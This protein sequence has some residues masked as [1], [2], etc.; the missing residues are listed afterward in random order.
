MRTYEIK[1]RESGRFYLLSIF[2]S[3][4]CFQQQEWDLALD[5][6][7]SKVMLQA[8]IDKARPEELPEDDRQPL[9]DSVCDSMPIPNPK[10]ITS[11]GNPKT[12]TLPSD[13]VYHSV[14]FRLPRIN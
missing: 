11:N 2:G 9:I 6:E 12:A 8:I 4:R 1:R 5:V 3:G 7:E 13:P 14:S 10:S